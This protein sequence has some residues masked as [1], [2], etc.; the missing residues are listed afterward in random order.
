LRKIEAESIWSSN[1]HIH[2]QSRS[3]CSREHRLHL[4]VLFSGILT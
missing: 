4:T 3:E 1:S 2:V